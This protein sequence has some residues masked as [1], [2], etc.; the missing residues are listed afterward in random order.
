ME[1]AANEKITSLVVLSLLLI[2]TI[3]LFY[4]QAHGAA[5]PSPLASSYNFGAPTVVEHVTGVDDQPSALQLS[6]SSILVAWRTNRAGPS[7]IYNIYLKTLNVSSSPPT[8]LPSV[9]L[10]TTGSNSYPS[11]SQFLNGTIILV[12][13]S[14]S[15][16]FDNLYFM[17]NTNRRWSSITQLTSGAFQDESAKIVI[18]PD[19]TLWLVW[20]RDTPTGLSKPAFY[21]Q[22][23]Y[24][25][26]SGA[27][28]W[29]AD[30]AITTNLSIDSRSPSV[31]FSNHGLLWFTWTRNATNAYNIVYRT[32]NGT[33]W[34]SDNVVTNTSSNDSYPFMVQDRN[35]TMWLFWSR[36]AIPAVNVLQYQLFDKFSGDVG[37]TWSVDGQLTTGGTVN[38][39]ALDIEPSA[40]QGYDN[41]LWLFYSS[42][43]FLQDFDLYYL[44]SGLVFPV[45]HV[46]VTNIQVSPTKAYPWGDA[47]QNMVTINVTVANLG[48][49]TESTLAL[50]A[51]AVN[52]TTI[53]VGTS[54][55]SPLDS[56]VTT[57]VLFSW[58]TLATHASAGR[59]T[60]VASIP[61][62]TG[63]TSETIGNAVDNRLANVYLEAV[64]LPG[65]LA[66]TYCITIIDASMMGKAF[67]TT[68]GSLN[69]NPDADLD[70]NGVITIIDFGILAAKFGKCV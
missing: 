56:N 31:T 5:R 35:G 28:S 7:W 69:W 41:R 53:T 13:T 46:A 70:N 34:S 27:N 29:T 64:L 66:K 54:L 18:T 68:P 58:D 30:T 32:L 14:N 55:M 1:N 2:P 38:N 22:I 48:D 25:T 10:T 40:I 11:L 44:N 59:Y 43:Q 67:G 3:Q 12:W 42:N 16:G 62:I 65:A 63:S 6:N 15:T 52:K 24:K 26:M 45:H 47:P 9:R 33:I 21:R 60:I 17:T 61:R 51:Q 20:E 37:K 8:W 57:F 50:T 19:S 4:V 36:A 49:Y 39:P 23:Y